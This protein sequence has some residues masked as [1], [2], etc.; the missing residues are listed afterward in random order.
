MCTE[1]ELFHPQI[2]SPHHLVLLQVL[3]SIADDDLPVLQ[4]VTAA[5]DREDHQGIL[6]D[7]QDGGALF[8]QAAD[9]G[10]VR[11]WGLGSERDTE[12]PSII[13]GAKD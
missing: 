8:I 2:R 12:I 4:D 7:Q 10:T 3:G 1:T 9:D 13:I 6:L 11:V 5:G